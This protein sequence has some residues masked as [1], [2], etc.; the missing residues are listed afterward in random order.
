MTHSHAIDLEIVAEA[1]RTDRF[2]YVGL[3]GSATKRARFPG[4]MRGGLSGE[5]H[6]LGWSEGKEDPAVI[7]ASTAAQLLMTSERLRRKTQSPDLR[8]RPVAP[9]LRLGPRRTLRRRFRALRREASPPSD[10]PSAEVDRRPLSES[11]S[12]GCKFEADYEGC[13]SGGLI[14]KGFDGTGLKLCSMA[15]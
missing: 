2:G 6:W 7:A 9:L 11:D 10:R 3:I 1:L 15:G 8:G 4:Q 14:R 12:S 5:C 13:A